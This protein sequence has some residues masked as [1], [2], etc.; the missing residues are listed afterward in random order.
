VYELSGVWSGCP[1]RSGFSPWPTCPPSLFFLFWSCAF[2]SFSSFPDYPFVPLQ[3]VLFLFFSRSLTFLLFLT[4]VWFVGNSRPKRVTSFLPPCVSQPPL[5]TIYNVFL[6]LL[7]LWSASGLPFP[8]DPS[9]D[10][11]VS[12][13][14]VPLQVEMIPL[15]LGG[16]ANSLQPF[17]FFLLFSPFQ[18]SF[19][20]GKRTSTFLAEVFLG[21]MDARLLFF[22]SSCVGICLLW[23]SRWLFSPNYWLYRRFPPPPPV[24]ISPVPLALPFVAGIYLR[25]VTYIPRL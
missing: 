1:L 16:L 19:L 6:L 22:C 18:P 5:L 15:D 8:L 9:K 7:T 21:L 10:N 13:F 14:C 11:G 2:P 23:S 24:L 4:L 12:L 17:D 25:N 3:S 20:Y